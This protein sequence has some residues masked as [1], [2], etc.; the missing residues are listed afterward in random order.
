VQ[1]A[2][3]HDEDGLDAHDRDLGR[4][5]EQPGGPERGG[6]EEGAEV[7]QHP[8]AAASRVRRPGI[9]VHAAE[10][11]RRRGIARH[12]GD[13]EH[14]AVPHEIGERPADERP[15]DSPGGERG[16][17]HPQGR[18]HAVRRNRRGDE[19]VAGG[20]KPA[21]SALDRAEEDQLPHVPKAEIMLVVPIPA[22]ARRT[23]SFRP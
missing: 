7:G 4:A 6:P 8:R 22:I 1:R 15:D 18:R 13:E 21:H 14:A 20:H 17:Q 16:L 9:L 12:A 19:R 23:M 11:D 3:V 5:E 10:D 2:D